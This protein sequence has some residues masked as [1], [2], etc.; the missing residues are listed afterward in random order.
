MPSVMSVLSEP[1]RYWPVHTPAMPSGQTTAAVVASVVASVSLMRPPPGVVV[2]L[3]GIL[4][5]LEGAPFAAAVA[6]AMSPPHADTPGLVLR[7]PR[8]RGS[9]R[10]SLKTGRVEVGAA[11]E[12][13]AGDFMLACV[14]RGVVEP[15]EGLMLL[16]LLLPS[17]SRASA[18]FE[19]LL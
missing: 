16:M 13:P 17:C 4:R 2:A 5:A 7:H 1:A 15:E 9:T 11:R 14:E 18:A 6:A 10:R 19:W 12:K 8:R 3:E